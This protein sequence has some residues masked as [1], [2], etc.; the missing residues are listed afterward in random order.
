M[1]TEPT[2]QTVTNEQVNAIRDEDS[3]QSSFLPQ[4]S[5][6]TSSATASLPP[7]PRG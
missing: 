7:S 5:S 2:A 3:W 6:G 4:L 1:T